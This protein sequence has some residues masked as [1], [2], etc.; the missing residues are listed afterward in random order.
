MSKR[1]TETKELA[2]R[3]LS[4]RLKALRADKGMTQLQ[5]SN[6]SGVSVGQIQ[7]IEQ[8]RSDS[9]ML[10]VDKLSK[11][12]GILPSEFLVGFGTKIEQSN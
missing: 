11:G 1:S 12:L 8:G 5:L 9:T 2:K 7:G 3:L 6:A 4:A 10:T